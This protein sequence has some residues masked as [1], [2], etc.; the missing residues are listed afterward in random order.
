MIEALSSVNLPAPRF[1]YS[2]LIKAGPFYKT[3]GMIALDKD[4]G[5]LESGGVGAETAKILNNLIQALPDF[6]LTLDELVSATIYTTQ[7]DQFPAINHAWEAVFTEDV[8]APARTALGVSALP[9]ATNV[10]IEF[11]FYKD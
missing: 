4:S 2:P 7:F 10:E 3:A 1:R 9:L 6:N 11:M 5:E 8:R